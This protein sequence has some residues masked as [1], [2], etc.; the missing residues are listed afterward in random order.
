MHMKNDDCQR[1]A[2]QAAEK[3]VSLAPLTMGQAFAG[4]FAIPDPDATKPKRKKP[5][6]PPK[7]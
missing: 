2:H 3:P 6:P 7:E 5:A 1:V 4:L